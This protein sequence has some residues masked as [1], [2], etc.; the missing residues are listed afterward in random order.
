MLV[1]AYHAT[2]RFPAVLSHCSNNFGPG[3][4]PEKLI[5]VVITA[6][7]GGRPIPLYG[8]GLHV[9]EWLY[10]EDTAEAL[11]T[12]L[13]RGKVGESYHIGGGKELANLQTVE[14]IC[15][16]VD[17]ALNR[18]LGTARKQIRH[19]TDRPG[20]DRRYSL[21]PG[22]LERELGWVPKTAFESGLRKTVLWYLQNRDHYASLKQ[23][24]H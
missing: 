16:L 24:L 6:I 4:F 11:W 1:R 21:N 18:P 15:D 23:P 20:H 14:M 5:P 17:E 9:R 3:Q 12:I 13:N 22:K 7:L 10:V 2:Y 8:D 19:V